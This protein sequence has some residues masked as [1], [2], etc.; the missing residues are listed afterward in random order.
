MK[1]PG[2]NYT[3]RN[4]IKQMF[5]AGHSAREISV[6]LNIELK[7]VESFGVKGATDIKVEQPALSIPGLP[8]VEN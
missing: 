3:D 6:A 8:K 7:C 4:N 2:A 1:K 5:D